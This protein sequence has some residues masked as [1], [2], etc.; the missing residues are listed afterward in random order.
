MIGNECEQWNRRY[1]TEDWFFGHSPNQ[2]LVEQIQQLCPS[3]KA[4][5]LSLGEGEGRDALW[6]A[7]QG[8]Q[9]TAI[10]GSE[11]GLQKL[12]RVAKQENLVIETIHRDLANYEPMKGQFEFV[13]SFFCHL[14][15]VLRSVVHHRAAQALKPNGYLILQAF[16]PGQRQ[17]NLSSGGPKDITMLYD[18]ACLEQDFAKYLEIIVLEE[19]KVTIDCGRHQG[20]AIIT[21]FVGK[22][23]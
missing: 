19:R 21:F 4:R 13:L 7:R 16:A 2:F 12:N 3:P 22:L 6:L 14:K 5:I 11:V 10:D 15:P 8:F 23:T 20:K 18:T 1:S 17:E 9:V